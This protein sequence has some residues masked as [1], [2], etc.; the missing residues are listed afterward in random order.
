MVIAASGMVSGG[1][2]VNYLKRML[3]DPRHCVLFTGYQGAGTTGRD[4]QRYGPRGGWV[5]LDGERITIRAR[6]ETV[7]GY[8]AHADGQDLLNFVRRPPRHIRLVH[9]ER[10]AQQALREALLNWAV[11][12]GHAMTVTLGVALA[13]G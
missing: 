3:G 11:E 12:A 10:H 1:R 4:I 2:V 8:S 7:S 9:G 6:V 13:E 5:E